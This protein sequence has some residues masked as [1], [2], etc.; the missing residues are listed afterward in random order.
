LLLVAALL[1]LWV[2]TTAT[3]VTFDWGG[4]VGR[5][6]NACDPQPWG[7]FGSVGYFYRIAKHEVTNAQYVEFLNAKAASDPH[8]LYNPNMT[9]GFNGG[10]GRS[11]SDGSYTYSAIAGREA[12]PVNFVSVFDAMRFVNWVYNGQGN[13]NTETGAYTMPASSHSL[14][15]ARN[16]GA[17]VFLPTNDEWHKAAYYDAD[18]GDFFDYPAGS[19]T[20]I[21]CSAPTSLPNTA[22]C[23]G[24]A[25]GFTPVGS[26]PGSPSPSGAFDQAGN[27]QEWTETEVEGIETWFIRGGS[28]GMTAEFNQASRQDDDYPDKEN[29]HV[30]F[31]VA[32]LADDPAGENC[33][34]GTCEEPENALTCPADCDDVCGDGLCTGDE[35]VLSCPGE[36][37]DVCGDGTCTG[38]ED[39]T[40]CASDCGSECGDGVCNGDEGT[41][42]C[43]SDCGQDCGDGVCNGSES[44]T[45]CFPDC[46]SCGDGLVEG[47]EQCEAGVPL[48]DSCQSL[49]FDSGTLACNASVCTYDT[50]DCTENACLP[51]FARCSNDSECCSGDCR[52][53]GR[54]R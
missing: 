10:I 6:G 25:G 38:D 11:G 41:T 39:T 42:N 14:P 35:D 17:W 16:S 51:R 48:D 43:V 31:R 50:S 24:V 46:V 34:N 4:T 22:N 44:S 49:G 19:D 5:P 23:G 8:G 53:W 2:A 45:T 28:S 26:Y 30:G 20:V 27:V 3:A 15:P 12:R 52:G 36:C 13:G 9:T 1:W 21:T 37:P 29:G 18:A 40:N 47:N 33:G 7:C 54:C 32:T